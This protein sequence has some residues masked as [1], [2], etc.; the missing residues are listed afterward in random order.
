MGD[1]QTKF[2]VNV[3][4]GDSKAKTRELAKELQA[5]KDTF[6]QS[7]GE[8][9][10]YRTQ[11]KN[12]DK[13]SSDYKARASE[14]QNNIKGVRAAMADNRKTAGDLRDRLQ[15]LKQKTKE[16]AD[17]A[18]V[19]E[20]RHKAVGGAIKAAGGPMGEVKGKLE[21]LKDAFSSGN[22]ASVLFVG[23]FALL[24]AAVLAATA[25]VLAGVVAFG[26][27]AI[28][29]ADAQRSLDLLQEAAAGSATNSAAMTTQIDAMARRVPTARAE[30]Q[31]LYEETFR[32]ADHT[33][34]SGGAIQSTYE[35][36][37]QSSAAMGDSVGKQIGDLITRSKEFGV[38]RIGRLDVQ[39]TGIDYEKDLVEPLAKSM[40]RVGPITQAAMAKARAQLQIGGLQMDAGA[41]LVADAVNSRFGGINLRQM[42]SLDVQWKR[43]KETFVSFTRGINLDPLIKAVQHFFAMFNTENDVGAAIKQIVEVLGNGMVGAVA[44]GGPAAEDFFKSLVI[45]AQE[46]VIAALE[47]KKSVADMFKFDVGDA[48]T[49]LKEVVELLKAAVSVLAAVNRARNFVANAL[50]NN[51]LGV[52]SGKAAAADLQ[53]Q[54][55]AYR[56]A[57]KAKGSTVGAYV[58]HDDGMG[59]VETSPAHAEGGVVGRPAPGE[60]WASVAPGETI[61]PVGA[62]GGGGGSARAVTVNLGGITIQAG[63]GTSKEIATAVT[64]SSFRQ[65]LLQEIV[66]LLTGAGLPDGSVPA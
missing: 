15:E 43:L 9:E 41:K 35:A 39:G 7:Q 13:T 37:A 12:L 17:A 42:L 3:D 31:K 59:T 45:D 2:S 19:S 22:A 4:D 5:L 56:D 32:L 57:H 46:L 25:A 49:N 34:M 28:G 47:G 6:K 30:L 51:D 1:L 38:I 26:K 50:V 21:A 14:V 33:R 52:E 8:I 64:S 65:Q 18:K 40:T 61:V 24:T 60:F 16:E 23:G 55:K 10:A 36:I 58:P 27:W 29:A 11:M 62:S 54:A 53:E 20:E 66:D 48:I 63:G 44:K